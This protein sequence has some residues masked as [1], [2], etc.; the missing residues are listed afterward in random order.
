MYTTYNRMFE[1]VTYFMRHPVYLNVKV[2]RFK[3]CDSTYTK[4]IQ[5]CEINHRLIAVLAHL[6]SIPNVDENKSSLKLKPHMLCEQHFAP[7]GIYG[8]CIYVLQN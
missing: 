2:H 8:F 5:I 6:V 4:C 1:S 3:S 7:Y